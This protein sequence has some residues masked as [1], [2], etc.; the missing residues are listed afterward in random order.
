[1]IS[2]R[3][4]VFLLNSL[5]QNERNRNHLASVNSNLSTEQRSDD[6]FVINHYQPV[7]L[8]LFPQPTAL[9]NREKRRKRATDDANSSGG[10][11]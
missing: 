1:M 7:E 6:S 11:R 2:P 3:Y 5:E 10:L 4:H 9:Q 8:F